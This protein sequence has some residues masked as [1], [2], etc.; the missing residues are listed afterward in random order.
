[1][2]IAKLSEKAIA[3]LDEIYS[4]IAEDDLAS[5]DRLADEFLEKFLM[6]AENPFSGRSRMELGVGF[7]SFPHRRYIVIYILF[8]DGIEIIRVLHS[9]RDVESQF[10]M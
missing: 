7:R 3:D 4:Y 9:A 8:A 1:M 2:P 6:L 10:E 5:A